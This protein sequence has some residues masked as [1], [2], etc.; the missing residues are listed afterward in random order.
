MKFTK[1]QVLAE[2]RA[3]EAGTTL[4]EDSAVYQAWAELADRW[5]ASGDNSYHTEGFKGFNERSPEEIVLDFHLN[6]L[7]DAPLTDAEFNACLDGHKRG[8]PHGPFDTQAEAEWF[9]RGVEYANSF[10]GDSGIDGPAPGTPYAQDGKWYVI[11]AI[12]EQDG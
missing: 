1:E 9:V 11:V 12:N 2:K 8:Q 5:L 4:R 10:Y 7:L 6:D 3:I